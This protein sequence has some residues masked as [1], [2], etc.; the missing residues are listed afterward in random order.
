[1]REVGEG[2]VLGD[3]V[4]G[5]AG[6]DDE[7][8]FIVGMVVVV[9]VVVRGKVS[10]SVFVLGA[11]VDQAFEGGLV[12]ESGDFGFT[13]VAGAEDYVFWME[14]PFFCCACC[15][16]AALYSDGPFFVGV[17][18]LG[19]LDRRGE[20]AVELHG[21][22][23]D[24]EPICQFVF[25]GE[26]GPVGGEGHKGHVGAV[27]GFNVRISTLAD[28]QVFPLGWQWDCSCGGKGR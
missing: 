20:P 25:W 12:W 23:V 7:D 9:V 4:A 16:V 18:V 21:G 13:R 2:V 14:G 11:V 19:G 22:G 5:V 24:L 3:V 1:M 26:E 27:F 28:L 8:A 6:T 17:A 15:F 10:E